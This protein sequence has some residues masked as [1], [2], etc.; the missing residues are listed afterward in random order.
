MVGAIAAA[1]RSESPKPDTHPTCRYLNQSYVPYMTGK[2]VNMYLCASKILCI[3]DR[4]S[5]QSVVK[6]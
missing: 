5:D 2:S 4:I 1:I 3:F 6:D